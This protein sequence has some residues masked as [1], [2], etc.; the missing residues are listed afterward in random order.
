MPGRLVAVVEALRHHTLDPGLEVA[1]QPGAG[2]RVPVRGHR[3]QAERRSGA[4]EELQQHGTPHPEWVAAQIGPPS[5]QDVEHDVALRGH[6]VGGGKALLQR[7]EVDPALAA[8][9]QLPVEHDLATELGAQGG[10]NLGEVM[11]EGAALA[12]LQPYPPGV[13]DREGAAS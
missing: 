1:A 4:V 2:S 11:A 9:A 10:D 6:V 13:A 7:G 12:G 8:H 5:R 3:D